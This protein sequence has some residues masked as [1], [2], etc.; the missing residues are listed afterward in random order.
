MRLIGRFVDSSQVTTYFGPTITRTIRAKGAE[1]IN[2]RIY[3]LLGEGLAAYDR[4]KFMDVSGRTISVPAR[5]RKGTPEKYLRPDMMCY[6]EDDAGWSTPV[7][8]GL[9]RLYEWDVDD[10]GYHYVAYSL[11]GWAILSPTLRLIKQVEEDTPFNARVFKYGGRYHLI[12]GHGTQGQL[13]DVTDPERPELVRVL[14][15]VIDA[16]VTPGWVAVSERGPGTTALNFYR[17]GDYVSGASP[18]KTITGRYF[19]T[20]ADD[21]GT[22]YA[23]EINDAQRKSVIHIFDGAHRQ[24]TVPGVRWWSLRYGDGHL[25]IAGQR[26]SGDRRQDVWLYRLTDGDPEYVDHGGHRSGHVQ[27]PITICELRAAVR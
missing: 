15:S 21:K 6:P 5:E 14:D 19:M 24:I 25:A 17:Q 13:F 23:V 16:S 26:Y 9:D 18:V 20:D 10:R 1:A 11:W 8:D 27:H 7:Y 2:N 3:V 12:V 4:D 22:I